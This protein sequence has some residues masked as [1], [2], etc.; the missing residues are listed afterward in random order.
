MLP[1]KN[2]PSIYSYHCDETFFYISE[3]NNFDIKV[4]KRNYLVLLTVYDVGSHVIC[5]RFRSPLYIQRTARE[6]FCLYIIINQLIVIIITIINSV[7][8]IVT[9]HFQ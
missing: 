2:S 4:T 7:G 8:K 9:F 1:N 5:A 6:I 3:V